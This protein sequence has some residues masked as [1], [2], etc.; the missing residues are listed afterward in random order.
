MYGVYGTTPGAGRASQGI[1][2][3]QR[4]AYPGALRAGGWAGGRMRTGKASCTPTHAP[5]A[6]AAC[7]TSSHVCDVDADVGRRRRQGTWYLAVRSCV[8][9]L[10]WKARC[11][12]HARSWD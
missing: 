9:E 7:G 8:H 12:W 4:V 3:A 10:V 6:L 5:L 1:Y 2:S 11:M